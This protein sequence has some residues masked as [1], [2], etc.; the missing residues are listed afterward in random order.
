MPLFVEHQ[1]SNFVVFALLIYRFFKHF[2]IFFLPN[3]SQSAS[4]VD[5]K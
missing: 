3:N 1:E 5:A 4:G 2:V